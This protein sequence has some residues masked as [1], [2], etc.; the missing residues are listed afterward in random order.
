[1]S[2]RRVGTGGKLSED[3]RSAALAPRDQAVSPIAMSSMAVRVSVFSV[4]QTVD[5]KTMSL[6]YLDA[7]RALGQS[8]ATKFVVPMEFTT[9]LRPLID[10]S[11]AAMQPRAGSTG[12]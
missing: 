1:M 5:S 2:P 4:A 9:M 10:L 7:L 3:A 11:A 8:P 6:Q 12:S